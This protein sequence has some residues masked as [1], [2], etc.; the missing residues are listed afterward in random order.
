MARLTSAGNPAGQF[1]P[2]K[3]DALD[4][5]FAAAGLCDSRALVLALNDVNV[6]FNLNLLAGSEQV[7]SKLVL[8]FHAIAAAAEELIQKLGAVEGAARFGLPEQIM[9]KSA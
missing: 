7:P 8:T 3:Y 4:A 1:P 2:E 9:K 5:V 6:R